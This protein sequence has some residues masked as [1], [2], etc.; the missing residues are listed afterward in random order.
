MNGW[1][2]FYF[3]TNN[4]KKRLVYYT[5]VG[6]LRTLLSQ[7]TNDT[8]IVWT[9]RTEL[10]RPYCIRFRIAV[11]QLT[12]NIIR[13]T[14]QITLCVIIRISITRIPITIRLNKNHGDLFVCLIETMNH[15]FW[16]G[17]H[18]T[19]YTKLNCM[20]GKK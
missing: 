8:I 5:F 17:S 20:V 14:T 15:L 10:T 18:S 2:Y 6:T 7:D 3:S 16:A 11:Q 13:V 4:R 12:V 9:T 19:T 1:S